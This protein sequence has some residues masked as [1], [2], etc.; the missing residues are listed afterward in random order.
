MQS[1]A[2]WL[3]GLGFAGMIAMLGVP[4]VAHQFANAPAWWRN[5]FYACAAV[6]ALGALLFAVGVF[7][8]RSG[9]KIEGEIET[10][11]NHGIGPF[12]DRFRSKVLLFVR[13]VNTAAPSGLFLHQV[14]GKDRFGNDLIVQRLF[15]PSVMAAGEAA[16][17]SFENLKIRALETGVSAVVPVG[18][19]LEG[20]TLAVDLSTLR[21]EFRDAWRKRYA[22]RPKQELYVA[23][24]GLTLGD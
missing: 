4:P 17:R 22:I 20:S 3:A 12:G 7:T 9:P 15:A 1:W 21:V 14:S 5:G 10:V 8:G 11:E 16:F 24:R 2:R 13:L 19:L 6:T 18:L 23:V